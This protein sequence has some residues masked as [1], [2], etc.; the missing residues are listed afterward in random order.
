MSHTPTEN[1]PSCSTAVEL[2]SSGHWA[3]SE[4]PCREQGLTQGWISPHSPSLEQHSALHSSGCEQEAAL[5]AAV[6]LQP[7]L[8]Q[9]LIPVNPKAPFG[10]QVPNW[11]FTASPK[12]FPSLTNSTSLHQC[13]QSSVHIQYHFQGMKMFKSFTF[14]GC[15]GC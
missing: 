13:D 8:Q 7:C 4:Q 2:F 12:N 15:P 11:I 3:L 1:L 14:P 10:I 9:T 6:V 5:R